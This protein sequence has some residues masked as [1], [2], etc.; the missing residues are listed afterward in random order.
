MLFGNRKVKKLR[1]VDRTYTR[2]QH[3]L[4]DYEAA[5]PIGRVRFEWC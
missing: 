3:L 5:E 2:E 4:D 1:G